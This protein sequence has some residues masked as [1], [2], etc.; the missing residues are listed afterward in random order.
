MVLICVMVSSKAEHIFV[1]LRG[2][3]DACIYL[4]TGLLTFGNIYCD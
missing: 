3:I 2:K 1:I 4:A